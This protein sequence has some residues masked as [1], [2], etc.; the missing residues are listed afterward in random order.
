MADVFISYASEDRDR[1]RPLAHALGTQGWSVWWDRHIVA[2]QTF[3]EVIE[4]ELTSARSVVTLWSASSIASEWVRNEAAVA[5]ERGVLVPALID[6]VA[7][8]LEF[9]R[10]QTVD[11]V[12]WDGSTSHEGFQ[13]LCRGITASVSGEVTSPREVTTSHREHVSRTKWFATAGI[14]AAVV[15]SAVAYWG[16][17]RE[18]SQPSEPPAAADA[19]PPRIEQPRAPSPP[20]EPSA[21]P[22]A[23]DRGSLSVAI[24]SD[25]VRLRWTA[26][27]VPLPDQGTESRNELR[28]PVSF[29]IRGQPA[30]VRR[31][32]VVTESAGAMTTWDGA[33]EADDEPVAEY[34]PADGEIRRHRKPLRPFELSAQ[35][36][37]VAKIID[38]VAVDPNPLG[39]GTFAIQLQVQSGSAEW[40]TVQKASFTVPADFTLAGRGP[41]GVE[42]HRYDRW[43]VFP[44]KSALR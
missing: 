14:V 11:L 43:Q 28:L 6:R 1:V 21:T 13:A 15:L 37:F 2:G 40:S 34:A 29:Q 24:D 8:P 38:F 44:L 10:K 17:P 36:S 27:S 42:F 4:R 39:A 5:A 22:K 19:T 20:L 16:W 23:T 12:G 7:L 25:V 9:R 31:V 26:V 3:D 41:S 30:V 33:Y 18:Q 35:S 32:R